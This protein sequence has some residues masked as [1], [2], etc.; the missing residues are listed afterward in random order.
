MEIDELC[1]H[2]LAQ[3]QPA[4]KHLRTVLMILK[5]SNDLERMGDHAVNMCQS[6][7]YLIERPQIKPLV[8]LPR[9]AEETTKMLKDSISAFINED[10]SL[11]RNVCERDSMVD[12][13]RDQIWRELISIMTSH[14]EAIERALNLMRFSR[15]LE[16]ISD[17]TT[18]I[19]EDVIFMVE[20]R[21]IKHHRD[22]GDQV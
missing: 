14:Q 19:C 18:N 13:L 9:M 17:L 3:F 22:E 1:A 7:L 10:S 20:G 11:A 15:N 12:Q 21:V 8:D 4:A 6:A 5:M 16:R 2:L